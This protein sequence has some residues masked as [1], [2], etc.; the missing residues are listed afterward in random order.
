FNSVVITAPSSNYSFYSN[1]EAEFNRINNYVIASNL[2]AGGIPV[3]NSSHVYVSAGASD[4]VNLNTLLLNSAAIFGDV[5]HTELC[6]TPNVPSTASLGAR[7][8]V[9]K[10]T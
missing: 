7:I 5:F 3:N 1:N 8:G 9:F 2:V 6:K 10:L 4:V